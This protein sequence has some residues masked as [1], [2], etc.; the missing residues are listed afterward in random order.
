MK[1]KLNFRD[2]LKD[3]VRANRLQMRDCAFQ[4]RKAMHQG[5]LARMTKWLILATLFRD[6]NRGYMEA[7]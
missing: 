6:L 4:Y 7:A 5:N 2:H 1:L 3:I